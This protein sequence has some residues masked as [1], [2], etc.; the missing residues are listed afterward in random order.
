[1]DDILKAILMS[2]GEEKTAIIVQNVSNFPNIININYSYLFH[3]NLVK[4][5]NSFY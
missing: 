5:I 2:K 3:L 4:R 1:M